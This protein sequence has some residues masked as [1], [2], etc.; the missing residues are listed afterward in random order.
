MAILGEVGLTGEIL[1]IAHLD[2]YIS[3]MEL[4]GITTCILPKQCQPDWPKNRKVDPVFVE[5]I[6]DA[7]RLF[8]TL[9]LKQN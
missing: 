6:F 9:A 3:A 1:P 7:Y 5:T 4:L 2:R 8:N